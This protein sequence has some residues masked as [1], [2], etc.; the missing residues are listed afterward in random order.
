MQFVA[1]DIIQSMFNTDFHSN[2]KYSCIKVFKKLKLKFGDIKNII[3][4]NIQVFPSDFDLD[5][6]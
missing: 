5:M 2:L 1:F 3:S 4:I 6:L